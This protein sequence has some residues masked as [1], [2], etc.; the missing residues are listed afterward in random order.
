MTR[1]DFIDGDRDD[2]EQEGQDETPASGL[3]RS[4]TLPTH[5]RQLRPKP[6]A[7][8][9]SPMDGR[10]LTGIEFWYGDCRRTD[11]ALQQSRLHDTSTGDMQDSP[12]SDSRFHKDNSRDSRR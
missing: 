9:L 3:D 4:I 1:G 2:G 8:R 6:A 12:D 10:R 7:L 11:G 5:A